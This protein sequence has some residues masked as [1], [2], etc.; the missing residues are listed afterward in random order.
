MKKMYNSKVKSHLHEQGTNSCI[1]SYN[2]TSFLYET[3]DPRYIN[4]RITKAQSDEII[5]RE[6]H[7]SWPHSF[8][9]KIKYPTSPS[10]LAVVSEAWLYMPCLAGGRPAFS[11]R[12]RSP[13]RWTSSVLH[14]FAFWLWRLLLVAAVVSAGAI[15]WRLMAVCYGFIADGGN[16]GGKYCF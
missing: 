5:T 2:V 10:Y 8:G 15:E 4:P 11:P 13:C 9:N 12:A 7:I 14:N 3:D 1:K 16:A 6:N